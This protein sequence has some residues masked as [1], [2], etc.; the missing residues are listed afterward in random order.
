[1]R[2][3]R[4]T[5]LLEA[6]MGHGPLSS[7]EHFRNNTWRQQRLLCKKMPEEGKPPSRRVD[8]RHVDFLA[9][10]CPFPAIGQRL[11]Q[12]AF[13]CSRE[14]PPAVPGVGTAQG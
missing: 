2:T 14:D 8:D 3:A 6:V 7:T 12:G 4:S 5:G 9:S 11:F 1:M 13:A 10:A